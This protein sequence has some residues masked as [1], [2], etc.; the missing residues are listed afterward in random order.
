MPKAYNI[1]DISVSWPVDGI[2]VPATLT[3][4]VPTGEG[5]VKNLFPAVI[6]VAGSGPTDRNWNTPLI[7]GTN[8]S[9]ALLAGVLAEAGFIVLRYDKLASG[10]HGKE[11][12]ERL[13]GRIRMQSHLDELAGGVRLLA[14]RDDVDASHIFGLGNSEGCLHVLHY[15]VQA[16]TLPFAGLILTAPPARAVGAL[17][18]AQI[19]AQLAAVPG[20]DPMLSAYDAAMADFVA[21]R[22]V[23]VDASLPESLRNLILSITY[24]GNLPFARELWVA[25]SLEPLSK[26]SAPVLIVIGKKDIQVDWQADG[27]LLE[28][29]A[30]EH[31]NIKIVYPE[32]ANHVLKFEP[33][34]STE[35]TAAY[36]MTTYSADDTVLDPETVEAITVWLSAHS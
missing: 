15:Q 31:A 9:A 14:A 25:D 8:G 36:V 6:M 2:D 34:A 28:S 11:N 26:V 10:P 4:P 24:P 29:F 5:H 1:N 18:H 17:A 12:A 16:A 3:L 27:A 30:R 7:P 13:K 23:N 19:A 22:P 33:K 21:D 32:N 35:L 20:G